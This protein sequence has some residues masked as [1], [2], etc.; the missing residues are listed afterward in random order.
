MHLRK[1]SVSVSAYLSA[2]HV[3]K[4]LL[5]SGEWQGERYEPIAGKAEADEGIES[6]KQFPSLFVCRNYTEKKVYN[7]N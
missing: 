1:V 4:Q 6:I 3:R 5:A 2:A 7:F